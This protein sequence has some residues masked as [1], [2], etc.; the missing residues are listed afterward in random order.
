[1]NVVPAWQAGITG[2]GIVVTILD[3]GLESDHPDIEHNYV[4]PIPKL[5]SVI[6]INLLN[7]FSPFTPTRILKRPMT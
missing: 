2:K 7:I 1:M 6:F 4:S 3:D 5:H